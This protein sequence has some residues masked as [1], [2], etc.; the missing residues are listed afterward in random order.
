MWVESDKEIVIASGFNV[1]LFN[2]D[3]HSFWITDHAKKVQSPYPEKG[4]IENRLNTGS[5]EVEID[6]QANNTSAIFL[7]IFT[8]SNQTDC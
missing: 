7:P 1:S 4:P 8:K 6:L 2:V 5:N 3:I